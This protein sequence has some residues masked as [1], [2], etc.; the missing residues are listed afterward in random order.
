MT[1]RAGSYCSRRLHAAIACYSRDFLDSHT[2]EMTFGA[3]LAS[4]ATITLSSAETVAGI[5][6]RD[7]STRS[8]NFLSSAAR[9]RARR[10]TSP[11]ARHS[12]LAY[13]RRAAH[14]GQH[15]PLRGGRFG[16]Q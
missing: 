7:R 6:S 8:A 5:N 9:P 12:I 10:V 2:F 3:R 13:P 16:S 4:S 15:N 1:S 11:S 14:Q